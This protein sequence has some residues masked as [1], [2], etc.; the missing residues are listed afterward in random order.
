MFKNRALEIYDK[1]RNGK[2]KF[3]EALSIKILQQKRLPEGS[4]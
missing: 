4:L 1:K 3:T 2:K